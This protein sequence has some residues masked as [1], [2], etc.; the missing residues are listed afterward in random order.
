MGNIYSI[1]RQTFNNERWMSRQETRNPLDLDV[2][3]KNTTHSR[4]TNKRKWSPLK[5]S[6][7]HK[8]FY[9]SR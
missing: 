9:V 8:M 6:R 3:T 4:S 1:Y 7:P 2:E 5:S